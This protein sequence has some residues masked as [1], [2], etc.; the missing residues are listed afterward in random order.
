MAS[1]MSPSVC[2]LASNFTGDSQ[3]DGLVQ[4]KY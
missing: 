4:R 1:L 2:G 3:L